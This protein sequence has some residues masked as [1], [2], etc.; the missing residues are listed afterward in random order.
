LQ[1]HRKKLGRILFIPRAVN[2]TQDPQTLGDFTKQNLRWQRGLF[3][4]LKKY[5]VGRQLHLIDMSI[6]YQ[7]LLVMI[8]LLQLFVLVP[9]II[10]MTGNWMIIPVML[11]TDFVANSII[12]LG[13]SVAIRRWNLL[14]AMPYFY[15]LRWLELGIFI[16]AFFE[17][18][19]LKRFQTDVKGWETKGRRYKL[20]TE[21]LQDV[22]Q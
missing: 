12:A 18:I 14:G 8:Y 15:F 7:L 19:I 10:I 6:G 16:R 2:Y 4:G 3:Q 1:V 5:K 13:S 22:A 21:A 9:M 11:A 20:S 17:V